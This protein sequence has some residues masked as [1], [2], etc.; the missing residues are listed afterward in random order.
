[1]GPGVKVGVHA[2]ILD[3]LVVAAGSVIEPGSVVTHHVPL[4]AIVS[5]HPAVIIGYTGTTTTLASPV[6][7]V[8][9][10][11]NTDLGV[12]GCHLYHLPLIPDLRGDLSVVEF[13]KTLPFQPKRCFW[14]F[15]VPSR[16]VR[17]EHAHRT[18][19]Q[20]L[21]CLRGSIHVVIDDGKHRAEVA[22]DHP[23]L[24]L[25]IPPLV[26]GIQYKYSP[27][28]VLLVLASDVYDSNE[29]IRDYA[30]FIE[31]ASRKGSTK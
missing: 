19:H 24:G 23:N 14:V 1:M 12:G 20:Y 13:G 11:G 31:L 15:N 6:P 25:H 18:L 8:S 30:E 2:T 3:G 28:A 16:E 26:W 9:A 4:N 29:Y 27:D 21:L 10:S 7:N 17:G 5:G 22:L